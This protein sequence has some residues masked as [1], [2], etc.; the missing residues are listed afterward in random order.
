MSCWNTK[1]CPSKLKR[2]ST[3]LLHGATAPLMAMGSRRR[4][5][6][7]GWELPVALPSS[8]I[9]TLA[10]KELQCTVPGCQ[11]APVH[12]QSP[13]R[14]MRQ[15]EQHSRFMHGGICG[16]AGAQEDQQPPMIHLY[17]NGLQGD[18]MSAFHLAVPPYAPAPLLH[19]LVPFPQHPSRKQNS[20]SL[21]QA[22]HSQ[23]RYLIILM[24]SNLLAFQV[25]IKIIFCVE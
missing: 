19:L 4:R 15:R 10:W 7:T 22:A 1:Q 9:Q 13:S 16:T 20:R 21:F 11:Q 17:T 24:Y 25:V 6:M 18:S 3:A 2:T 8:N 14:G 23:R 12:G 5:V